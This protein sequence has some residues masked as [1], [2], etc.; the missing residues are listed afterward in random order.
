MWRRIEGVDG[1]AYWNFTYD[2]TFDKHN[3]RKVGLLDLL[4]KLNVLQ[5]IE[6]IEDISIE[7]EILIKERH[8]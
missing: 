3:L 1:C 5:H 8:E 6:D 4:S 2:V 7:Y